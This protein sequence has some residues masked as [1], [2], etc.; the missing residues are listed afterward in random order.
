[1]FQPV[2]VVSTFG[3][4]PQRQCIS[5]L[6]H[7]CLFCMFK[8]HNL[9]VQIKTVEPDIFRYITHFHDSTPFS[10]HLCHFYG[11][12]HCIDLGG[13]QS[14]HATRPLLGPLYTS[15]PVKGL[16]RALTTLLEPEPSWYLL[17]LTQNQRTILCPAKARHWQRVW[18]EETS[19]CPHFL[20]MVLS[21]RP[22]MFRCR[23]GEE[24]QVNNPV[25]SLYYFLSKANRFLAILSKGHSMTSFDWQGG[26]S[27][28]QTAK[29]PP[30]PTLYASR[31]HDHCPLYITIRLQIKNR[32]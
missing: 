26:D 11:E 19:S 7:I 16:K 22:I 32:N 18:Q 28:Y 4:L 8:H 23:L 10:W 21:E 30:P 25:T 5:L 17:A 1:M 12:G 13:H 27:H 3:C 6:L 20:H 14:P 2:S 31:W 24:C 15:D 9:E 29:E